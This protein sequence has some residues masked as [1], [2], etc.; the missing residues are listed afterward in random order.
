MVVDVT[1]VTEG[2]I[3]AKSTCGGVGGIGNINSTIDRLC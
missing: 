3:D 2:V 1:A